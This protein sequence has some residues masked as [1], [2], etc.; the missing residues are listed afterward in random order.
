MGYLKRKLSVLVGLVLLSGP[1][2]AQIPDTNAERHPETWE[3]HF[4]VGKSE[5]DLDWNGNRVTLQ[6]CIDRVHQIVNRNEFTIE[7]I[8]IVGYAS[9]EGSLQLNQR[10]SAERAEVLKDYLAAQTNMPDSL[11]KVVAGGENWEELKVMVMQTD[12]QYRDE[13]I[14]I[15]DSTPVGKDPEPALRKLPGGT[16]SY[17]LLNLYPKLRSAS[18][19]QVLQRVPII[20][21]AVVEPEVTERLVEDT[22]RIAPQKPMPSEP[23]PEP[24]RC[25]PPFMAIKTNL[26]QW[27][28]LI[29]PNIELEF[30]MGQRMSFAA[31]GMYR[32]I[33]DKKAKGNS[34]NVASVS[35]ELRLYLRND[36]SFQGHYFGLYGLYGEYDVKFGENGRQG[37][38]RGV[39]LAYGY[40]FKFN[41]FDCLYF[42]LGLGAGYNRLRYDKYYW[43]DP[44]NAFRSERGRNYWGLA[45]LKASLVWRF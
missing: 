17:M 16:Y 12:M 14:E 41:R 19:V 3:V 22:A 26:A 20:E 9:P 5:L 34:Y 37:D 40:I 23:E 2:W 27:A 13:V 11:F 35:P 32:W 30:Y 7:E 33:K 42:D 44:C 29:S 31:E 39:G 21:A 38:I 4:K 15:I 18:S 10:L 45:K 28:A 6:R 24:C 1:V 8:R 25:E 43:Y 36:R